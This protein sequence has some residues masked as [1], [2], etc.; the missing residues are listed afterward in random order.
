MK[1]FDTFSRGLIHGKE[2]TRTSLFSRNSS[3]LE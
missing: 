3:S 2:I 1:Y